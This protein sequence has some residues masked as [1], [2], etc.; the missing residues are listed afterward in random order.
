MNNNSKTEVKLLKKAL[1]EIENLQKKIAAKEPEGWEGSK[2]RLILNTEIK[3]F[4]EKAV[5]FPDISTMK[6]IRVVLDITYDPNKQDSEV[7]L[8]SPQ[9]HRIV[10]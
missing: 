10:F 9:D 3:N 6:T 5:D 2:R 8:M 4:L 7:K 1:W